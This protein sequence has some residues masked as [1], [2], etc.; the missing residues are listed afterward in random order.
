MAR[1]ST[2]FRPEARAAPDSARPRVLALSDFA[3][4]ERGGGVERAIAEI[5]TRIVASRSADVVVLALAIRGCRRA[6]RRP[7]PRLS[8]RRAGPWR[9]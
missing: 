3:P 9:A 1:G 6:R 2:P 7:G 5:Y 8:E 4:P